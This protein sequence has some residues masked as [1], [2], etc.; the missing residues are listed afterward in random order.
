MFIKLK[1]LTIQ[2]RQSREVLN[3]DSQ[4]IYFHGRISTGKSSVA[5]LIDYCLGN[6]LHPTPALQKEL[7]SAALGADIG[8][9]EVLFERSIGTSVI[10]VSWRNSKGEATVVAA[11]TGAGDKPIWSDDVFNLSDLIFYLTGTKAPKVRRNKRDP[12]AP[13]IRLSFRDLMWYCYLEQ[14]R[15]DSSFFRL[16]DDIRGPKSRDVMRFIL[17]Y[18]SERLGELE[19]RL[20]RAKEDRVG[21]VEAAKQI[22]EFLTEFGFASEADFV[23]ATSK[24][25]AELQDAKGRY[26]ELRKN[27]NA[28]THF[29]D[30]L[31]NGL[32]TMSEQLG[33]EEQVLADLEDKITQQTALRLELISAKFKLTRAETATAVL[34]QIVFAACPSCGTDLTRRVRN[35]GECYLCGSVPGQQNPELTGALASDLDSRIA[36]IEDSLTGH[37]IA[38]R[39]QVRR[40][41]RLRN[42]KSSLDELLNDEL[43][44]Y[45]SAFLSNSRELERRI[46]A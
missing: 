45:D 44:A 10:T 46:A 11:P 43:S 34:G 9:N 17:G 8:E 14:K 31:R 30:D 24:V 22:R 26:T 16:E 35:E 23:L 41:Q 12:D 33:T 42:E 37:K 39:R 6:G 3:L 25:Q 5:R 29:A 15:L 36:E 27:S 38:R 28:Q 21:K 2:F 18:Y 13:L 19:L 20:D 7:V 32:R 4:M 40:V 1:S